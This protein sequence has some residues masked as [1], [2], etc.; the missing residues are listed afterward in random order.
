MDSKILKEIRDS[1]AEIKALAVAPRLISCNLPETDLDEL[2]NNLLDGSLKPGQFIN[3]TPMYA[4]PVVRDAISIIRD[5][6]TMAFDNRDVVH[7]FVDY[8]PHVHLVSV[9]AG[10]V[11]IYFEDVEHLSENVWLNDP[12]NL[13][14]PIAELLAIESR[15]TEIVATAREQAKPSASANDA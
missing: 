12:I 7:I 6:F 10:T 2:K 14:D 1:L 5:I 8:A 15:L 11:D 13:E 3:P 9:R 4:V